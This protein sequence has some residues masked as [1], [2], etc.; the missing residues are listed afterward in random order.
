[1]GRICQKRLLKSII[2][3]IGDTLYAI[4]DS[5]ASVSSKLLGQ[6]LTAD[7]MQKA[8]TTNANFV[9]GWQEVRN[10]ANMFIV[11]GFVIVG[12]AFTLRI[13]GYGTKKALMNLILIALVINFSGVFCG[14]F[15][16]A[17]NIA[18]DTFLKGGSGV[19]TTI[20]NTIASTGQQCQGA[21]ARGCVDWQKMADEYNVTGYIKAALSFAI[22]FVMLAISMFYLSFIL[23]ARQAVLAILFILSPLAFALWIFPFSRK[24][25][26]EWWTNFLK[27]IFIGD[28]GAFFI[29]IAAKVLGS[30][31]NPTEF[32]YITIMVFLFVG[33]KITAKN[34]GAG[35]IAAATV[36]GATKAAAGVAIGAVPGATAAGMKMLN[37]ATG[38][39]T[40]AAT[41][42]VKQ[43]YGRAMERVGLRSTGGTDKIVQEN[44]KKQAEGYSTAYAAAKVRGDQAEM[45]R[46]KNYALKGKGQTQAA[47]M[48]ALKD[49]DAVLDAFKNE[50]GQMDA[51]GYQ[52]LNQSIQYA[53][54]AGAKDLRKD[55]SKSNPMLAGEGKI[56]EAVQKQAP[57]EFV[58]NISHE[59]MAHPEVFAHMTEDQVSYIMNPKNASKIDPRKRKAFLSMATPRT[60]DGKRNPNGASMKEYLQGIKKT[61]NALFTQT[62]KRIVDVQKEGKIKSERQ[63][64][65]EELNKVTEE[66]NKAIDADAMEETVARQMKEADLAEKEKQMYE[67][68]KKEGRLTPEEKNKETDAA[69]KEYMAKRKAEEDRLAE[70]FKQIDQNKKT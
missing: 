2:K 8:I 45:N 56:K 26:N 10:L 6:V 30:L 31:Q 35:T 39:R 11:I 42:K 38:G 1:M 50:K 36:L 17:S 24:W 34:G 62:R 14:L 57:A 40:S 48:V 64:K 25:F 29:Y 37:A 18:M 44:V 21:N 7:F 32:D 60:D 47:A 52:Q 12:V 68:R 54:S 22:L 33:F 69:Y 13:E 5:L 27:W 46:I 63:W 66:R 65:T 67:L 3:A 55:L 61:D 58:K 53:E 59:A 15:I 70:Q 49:N 16:D 20:Y 19:G 4:G 9:S 51:R 23:I 41:E 28:I 43:G